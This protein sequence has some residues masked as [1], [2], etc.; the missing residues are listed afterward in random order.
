MAERVMAGPGSAP[1]SRA[2]EGVLAIADF[3]C[4]SYCSSDAIALSRFFRRD[5]ETSTRAACAYLII[6]GRGRAVGRARGVGA[7]LGVAVGLGVDVGVTVGVVVAVAVG[8]AVAVAVAVAVGVGVGVG[9][10]VA[11]TIAYACVS[12]L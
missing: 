9:V 8:V 1:V 7:C 12:P 4:G 5:A 11:G 6:Y 3:S 10:G 2:G